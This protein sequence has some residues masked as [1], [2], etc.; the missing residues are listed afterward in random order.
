MLHARTKIAI[1]NGQFREDLWHRLTEFIIHIP[2]LRERP[3]DIIPLSQFLLSNNQKTI[4]LSNKT[5]KTL[6]N[7]PWTGNIRELKNCIHRA[8]ILTNNNIIEPEHLQLL[9]NISI[10]K[11]ENNLQIP[12]NSTLKDA[13]KSTEK[14]LIE[15][16]LQ[17]TNY[18]KLQASKK[19][20]MYYASFCRK[21]KE[22]SL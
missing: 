14:K 3:E 21:I 7:H 16:T 12:I 1:K 15:Y 20:N 4:K 17:Q 22:H 10:K 2:P 18:N 11:E 19:L 5:I 8:T 6:K 9:D 13:L